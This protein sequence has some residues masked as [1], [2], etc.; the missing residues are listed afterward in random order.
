[1]ATMFWTTLFN[2]IDHSYNYGESS[3]KRI[4]ISFFQNTVL[5]YECMCDEGWTGRNCDENI[6]ECASNPCRNG[7]TCKVRPIA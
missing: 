1:M 2:L 7:A 4:L 3:F 5:N 6:D